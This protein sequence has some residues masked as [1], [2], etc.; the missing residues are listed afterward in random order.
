MEAIRKAPPTLSGTQ[1]LPVVQELISQRSLLSALEVMG[2][3]LGPVFQVKLPTF[4]PVVLSGPET[5]RQ[6]LVTERQKFLWR[7]ELDP[8]TRLLGKGLLV[9]DGSSHEV[10][11]GYMQP[12]LNR[13]KVMDHLPVM[14]AYTDHIMSR[15]SDGSIQDMLVEMRR[16]TLMIL[17]GTLFG[18]DVRPDLERIWDPVLRVLKYISPGLWLFAPR[19]P[20]P[21]YQS[22]IE[23][24][25]DY[26]Y[27][28]IR[29]RRQSKF[30]RDDMLSDLVRREDM[31]DDLIRDQLL[32]MLIAGHDTSTALLAWSFYVL[33]Q[34][35][36]VLEDLRTE[37]DEAIGDQLPTRNSLAKL[38]LMD[39]V[40][41]E[42]LRLYPPIHAGN[43]I[44]G[45]DLQIQGCPIPEGNRVLLSI[46][47]THRDEKYW[48]GAERFIPERFDRKK[49]ARRPALSYI[50]FGA[51]P[52]NC[53]G[54]AF[55]QLETKAVLAR[56]IQSFDLEL[57]SVRVNK[58]MAAT[59][60][61]RPGVLVQVSRRKR[62]ICKPTT[63]LLNLEDV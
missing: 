43:R 49:A 5:A 60:E 54:A 48:P 37:V 46:Y 12:Y 51:G 23:K 29:K 10:L 2:D 1:G 56:V 13:S 55:A 58:H 42:T 61:P 21:G 25:D 34:H 53:I 41:K 36:H 6:V 38:H 8:V 3:V 24:L 16:L 32:T 59:I 30:D 40:I 9:E 39:Q 63:N 62:K 28:I 35:S 4:Q 11:R 19:L 18:V 15:W 26:L 14:L 47:L 45:E 31:T 33:G 22:A 20:R 44:A 50:P 17:I 52:R 57:V 27:G 7:N